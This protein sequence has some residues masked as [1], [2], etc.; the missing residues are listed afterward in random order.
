MV[1]LVH[2]NGRSGLWAWVAEAAQG[3]GR[4]RQ[5]GELSAKLVGQAQDDA[6]AQAV[7]AGGVEIGRRTGAVVADPEM[8]F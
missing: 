3:A 7:A 5:D 6:Q 2:R 8:A 4:R 1:C